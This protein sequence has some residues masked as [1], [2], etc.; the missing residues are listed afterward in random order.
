VPRLLGHVEQPAARDSRFEIHECRSVSG[1]RG[2]T[3]ARVSVRCQSIV[4]LGHC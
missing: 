2:R 4:P 3:L 1:G